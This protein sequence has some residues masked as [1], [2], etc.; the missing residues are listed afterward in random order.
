MQQLNPVSEHWVRRIIAD[1]LKG[2]PGGGPG[3]GPGG[4]SV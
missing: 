3:G 1:I 4:F 2:V